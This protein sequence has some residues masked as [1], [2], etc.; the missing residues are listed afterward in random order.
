MAAAPHESP[1]IYDLCYRLPGDPFL[2]KLDHGVRLSDGLSWQKDSAT[3]DLPLGNI[4]AVH[5][6]SCRPKLVVDRCAITFADSSKLTVVNCGPGGYADAVRAPLCRQFVRDLHFRLAAGGC[7]T[8]RFTSGV[9]S[10]ALPFDARLHDR[11]RTA[12]RHARTRAALVR[13]V[14]SRRQ[15]QRLPR[16]RRPTI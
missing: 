6:M 13:T 9:P 2:H 16:R 10:L 14:Q 12:W 11:R 3:I 1:R 15:R 7:T 5:L 8:I 4:V